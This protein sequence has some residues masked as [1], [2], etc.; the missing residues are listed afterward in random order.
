MKQEECVVNS[1]EVMPKCESPLPC[2]QLA[3]ETENNELL[4]V[5]SNNEVLVTNSQPAIETTLTKIKP[6]IEVQEEGITEIS[7]KLQD[8]AHVDKNETVPSDTA[9]I[10]QQSETEAGIRLEIC[11]I[12]HLET[13]IDMQSNQV[14]I[15]I[16]GLS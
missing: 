15:T 8:N 11:E 10:L 3:P 9:V 12:D 6:S 14:S 13:N 1:D 16:L 4:L 2:G 5:E 7:E